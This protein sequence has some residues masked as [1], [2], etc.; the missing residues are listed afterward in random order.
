[1]S[2]PFTHE[3]HVAFIKERQR[4][5]KERTIGNLIRLDE[6][7][8]HR[9]LRRMLLL[10]KKFDNNMDKVRAAMGDNQYDVA[11][12]EFVCRAGDPNRFNE[13]TGGWVIWP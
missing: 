12:G 8:G 4:L 2:N 7:P 9:A 3:N 13:K 6:H 10:K 1:M 5:E 11:D